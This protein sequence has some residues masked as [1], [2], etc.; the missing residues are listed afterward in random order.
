MSLFWRKKHLF[1]GT[2]AGGGAVTSLGTIYSGAARH[3]SL[4]CT[5]VQTSLALTNVFAAF[6]SYTLIGG[7]I[8]QAVR[9][10]D[11]NPAVTGYMDG[12][13]AGTLDITMGGSGNLAASFDV[14]AQNCDVTAAIYVVGLEIP[15]TDDTHPT[16]P[17][18]LVIRRGRGEATPTTWTTLYELPLAAG[19]VCAVRA[20]AHVRQDLGA[21]IYLAAC[22]RWLVL[23]KNISGTV[24][25][26]GDNRDSGNA[27]YDYSLNN[28]GS[29]SC[30]LRTI[31]G[32]NTV[33][34]QCNGNTGDLVYSFF[35]ESA[36]I[37]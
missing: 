1:K 10:C 7:G 30:D 31:A 6:H 21:G 2:V 37:L 19:Q 23:A 5:M 25:I 3:M 34:F 36:L 13:T 20:R 28:A 26:V 22:A 29:A 14:A 33:K 32:T 9:G 4:E 35:I 18:N 17:T 27:F 11:Y 16:T 24:T 8:T 15:T 12:G